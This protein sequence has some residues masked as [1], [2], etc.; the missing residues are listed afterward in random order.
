LAKDR[1]SRL[2][3]IEPPDF[4]IIFKKINGEVKWK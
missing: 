4:Q 2:D 1:S 3:P